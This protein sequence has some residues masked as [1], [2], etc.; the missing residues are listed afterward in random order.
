M[1]YETHVLVKGKDLLTREHDH[2]T[3]RENTVSITKRKKNASD[4]DKKL[5]NGT[6]G[7]QSRMT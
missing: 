6:P 3:K 7:I 1:L 5:G 2:G 4:E